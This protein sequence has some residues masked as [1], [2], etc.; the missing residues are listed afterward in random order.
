MRIE[1]II[2]SLVIAL[3]LT[4]CVSSKKIFLSGDVLVIK[5]EELTKYWIPKREKFRLNINFKKKGFVKY[6]YIIDSNGNLFNPEV[7]ESRPEGVVDN[8]GLVALSKLKYKPAKTNQNHT[9]V[10]VITEIVFQ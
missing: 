4:S 7:V 10:Q 6:K 3:L 2:R 1:N 5:S 8:A 9:P